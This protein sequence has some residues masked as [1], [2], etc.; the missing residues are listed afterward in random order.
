MPVTLWVM[1]NVSLPLV[2]RRGEIAV[3]FATDNGETYRA[4]RSVGAGSK[5][6]LA[7]EL[8]GIF[9][10]EDHSGA[11]ETEARIKELL[12]L[13]RGRSLWLINLKLVDRPLPK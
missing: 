12:G 9:E 5:W 3:T 7:K 4:S 8:A 13:D 11:Q 10:V 1:S 2:P 6:L